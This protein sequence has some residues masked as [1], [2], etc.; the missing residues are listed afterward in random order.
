[1]KTLAKWTIAEYHALIDNGFLDHKNVELLNGELIEMAPESPIHRHIMRR[2]NRYLQNLL[3]E[4]A[5]VYEGHPITLSNSEPEPDL[6]IIKPSEERYIARHPNATD[7]FWLI[8]VSKSTLAYDLNDKKT[9][10]AKE[11]IQEYWVIDIQNK[12]LHVFKD[13]QDDQYHSLIIHTDGI[14][15]PYAFPDLAISV[16]E[17]FA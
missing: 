3:G 4:Y 11:G 13:L 5:L 17:L 9:V 15:S 2:G 12:R 7:I 8:E 6:A 1:M 10:Y 16:K 14:I